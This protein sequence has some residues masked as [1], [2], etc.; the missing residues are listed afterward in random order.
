MAEHHAT[1]WDGGWLIWDVLSTTHLGYDTHTGP[2]IG[3]HLHTHL[4]FYAAA[5]MRLASRAGAPARD[6]LRASRP[7]RLLVSTLDYPNPMWCMVR[8]TWPLSIT[9]PH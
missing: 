5:H 8:A 9:T 2:Y 7:E 6:L 1:P 4:R 3:S